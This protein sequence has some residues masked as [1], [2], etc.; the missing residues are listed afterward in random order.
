MGATENNGLVRLIG[1]H[2]TLRLDE[3]G[4]FRLPDD[5]AGALQRE[6]GRTAQANGAAAAMPAGRLALYFVPGTENRVFLYP[7]PNIDLAVDR[8]ENPPPGMDPQQVRRARDYFYYR[9]RF[10]EA[11]K[12]NR[13]QV[14]EGVRQHAE[15]DEDVQHVSLVAHGNWL[16]LSRSDAEDQRALDNRAAFEMAAP[17]LLNPVYRQP[18]RPVAETPAEDDQS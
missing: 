9:M 17:D 5:L 4:R 13:F 12:Q 11:D 14:P 1:Y 10:V 7:A 16:S 8:F 15:I 18:Q 3:R 2:E 6:L